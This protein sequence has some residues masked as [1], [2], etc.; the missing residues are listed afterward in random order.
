MVCS[1]Q[2]VNSFLLIYMLSQSFIIEA[3]GACCSLLAV[4]YLRKQS[5][6]YWPFNLINSVIY[7]FVFYYKGLYAQMSMQLVY[8]ALCIYGIVEWLK[9]IN[10]GKTVAVM[11]MP[12]KVFVGILLL[13][14]LLTSILYFVLGHYTDSNVPFL[15][16]L[17]TS[18]SLIGTWL[19][20]KRYIETWLIWIV[21]DVVGIS[22][23]IEKEMYPTAVLYFVFIG[24]ATHGYFL[25]KRS[26]AS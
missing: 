25:W 1:L 2:I 6:L 3:S 17:I 13:G 26:L 4:W 15:D 22:L 7:L 8:I 20:T 24:M 12:Q 21:I 16:A 10:A 14:S 5:I 11:H 23:F 19:F 9:H 18:F